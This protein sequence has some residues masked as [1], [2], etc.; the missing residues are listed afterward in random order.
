MNCWFGVPTE[1]SVVGRELSWIRLDRYFSGTVE[2]PRIS[3]QP[4]IMPMNDY[5]SRRGLNHLSPRMG[6]IIAI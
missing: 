4:L 6:C 3:V 2:Q 5:Y 1:P